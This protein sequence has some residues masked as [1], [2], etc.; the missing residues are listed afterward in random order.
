M[1]IK[2]IRVVRGHIPFITGNNSKRNIRPTN[3]GKKFAAR[4]VPKT[5]KGDFLPTWS[6]SPDPLQ[7]LVQ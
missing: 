7:S 5:T 1:L 6:P 4:L 2:H 3:Q